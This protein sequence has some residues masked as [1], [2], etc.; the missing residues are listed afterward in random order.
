[1]RRKPYTKR[2]L[3]RVSCVHC[4]APSSEQWR[5]DFCADNHAVEWL[6]LCLACDVELNRH[7][8]TFFNIAGAEAKVAR[9][10][11]SK[12]NEKNA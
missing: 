11:K 5:K 1:M 8:L 4:G 2:G 7:L 9:Y 3:A 6:P 12:R 10:E